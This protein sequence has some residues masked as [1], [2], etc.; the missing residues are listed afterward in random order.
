MNL[1]L[2]APSP[3]P[4]LASLPDADRT[5][6]GEALR[7]LLT[8]GSILGLEPGSGEI[9]AWCRQNLAWLREVADLTGLQIF[10]EHES[11]LVQA[12]PRVASLRLQLRGDATV[13]LLA[14]WYE[15]DQQLREQ[16]RDEVLLTVEQLNQLLREK[17]L[18]DLK[19]TPRA[20]RMGE[21]LRLAAR[22]HS[23]P[24]LSSGAIRAIADRGST[25][26]STGDSIPGHCRLDAH[27]GAA[28]AAGR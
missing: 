20:G 11:R 2:N 8:H 28:S 9:Y 23:R 7:E 3:V 5:Y 6:L 21:I 25:N 17:L 19:E 24:V 18:P 10:L 16:G 14:L 27:C 15:Q 22:H 4:L 1:D 13:V 26:T 12:I